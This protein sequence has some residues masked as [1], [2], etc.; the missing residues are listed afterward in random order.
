MRPPEVFVRP[1]TPEEGQRLKSRSR[2]AKHLATRQRAMILLASHTGM[3]APEIARA[4]Q[5]DDSHVRKVIHDFNERGFEAL[6]PSFRGGRPRRIS[7]DQRVRIVAVAGARPD[8]QGVPLS[9]WS[10]RR[11]ARHLAGEGIRVSPAHLGRILKEA[12]LRFL[13]TRTWKASPDPDFEAKAA[14]VPALYRSPPAD[15]GVV[16]SFGEMGPISL[17]PHQGAGWAPA[18]R[19]QRLRATYTRRQGIRYLVGA[20]DVHRDY[21][22]A[23]MRP[24]R[25]GAST[26]TFMKMIR[27]AYPARRRIYWIQDNLSAH[28]TPDI[29]AWAAGANVELVPTPTYASYLNRIESHFFPIQEFVVKNADYPDW[30]ACERAM[31]EHIRYRNGPHRNARLLELEARHRVAA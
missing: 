2:R 13:R 11:L 8:R 21:L 29:R 28:W 5:T 23:R 16:I 30:P 22:R 31:A 24:T 4:L 18:R 15:G 1:L 3:S 10:L 19:P 6:R 25:N 12:G 26:L 20:L 9:R 17:M 27:L 14:R 7:D